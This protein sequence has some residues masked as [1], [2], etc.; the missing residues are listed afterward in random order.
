M[1]QRDAL[2]VSVQAAFKEGDSLCKAGQVGTNQ[3]LSPQ[4][5]R[6]KKLRLKCTQSSASG[7]YNMHSYFCEQTSL[8]RPCMF[9][10]AKLQ[11][12]TRG[13]KG[14]Q[15]PL[16]ASAVMALYMPWFGWGTKTQ[17]SVTF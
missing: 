6:P 2:L 10:I 15:F 13:K 16:I 9:I 3:L 7:F 1:G 11:R 5:H 14:G 12:Q 4:S 17:Q 8:A